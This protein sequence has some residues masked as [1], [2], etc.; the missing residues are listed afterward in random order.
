VAPVKR[1]KAA[2][3][4]GCR[5]GD[6]VTLDYDRLCAASAYE[7]GD[8]GTDCA[9]AADHHA[10]GRTHTATVSGS[11]SRFQ[12]ALIP[13]VV[14][15]GTLCSRRPPGATPR[16]LRPAGLGAFADQALLFLGQGGVDVVG[17]QVLDDRHA[18]H[19]AVLVAE[20]L[21]GFDE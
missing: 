12:G 5:A 3:L 10:L 11:T 2:R 1:Q 15:L 8:R 20:D 21:L 6:L 13:P 18:R 4:A 16:A 17:R 19:L 7:V 9:T 14:A